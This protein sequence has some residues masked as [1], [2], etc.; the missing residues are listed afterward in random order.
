MRW[1]NAERNEIVVAFTTMAEVFGVEFTELRAVGYMKALSD[2]SADEITRAASYII[3][4]GQFF[5]KP[6]EII[7]AINMHKPQPIPI[8]SQATQEA[9][10]V[11][12]LV[13]AGKR[14]LSEGDKADLMA[15]TLYL[16]STRFNLGTL[17]NT[18]KE[19]EEH[20]FIK[21]FTAQW[22]NVEEFHKDE[23]LALTGPERKRI[24][25][26]VGGFV[27]PPELEKRRGNDHIGDR[28]EA[29]RD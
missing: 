10:K 26:P 29:G 12:G 1:T 14:S 9:N 11:L 28:D 8:E 20:W 5:P 2:F 27:M 17:C 25:N 21:D 7:K 24:S 6:V 4:N 22:A 15:T 3:H 23:A 18:M 16:L 19:A 13:R